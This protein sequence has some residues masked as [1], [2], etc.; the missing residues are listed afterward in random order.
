MPVGPPEQEALHADA[1]LTAVEVSMARGQVA[2]HGAPLVP[3]ILGVRALPLAGH[4]PTVPLGPQPIPAGVAMK[5]TVGLLVVSIVAPLLEV[6]RVAW[7]VTFQP[8]P[9][10]VVSCTLYGANGKKKIVP[11][12][13]LGTETV[14][15]V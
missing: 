13:P 15:D 6:K 9:L 10:P 5:R 14:R 7:N 4:D 1:I 12:M 11:V 2:L 3:Q 8:L